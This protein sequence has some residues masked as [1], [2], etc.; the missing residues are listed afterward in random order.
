MLNS[1]KTIYY[2]TVGWIFHPDEYE[3][4]HLAWKLVRE[5]REWVHERLLRD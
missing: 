3:R 5:H 4:Y 2:L 1:I